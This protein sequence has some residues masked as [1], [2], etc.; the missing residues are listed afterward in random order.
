[1]PRVSMTPSGDLPIVSNEVEFVKV[2]FDVD[3]L[4]SANAEAVYVGGRPVA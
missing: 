1:M 4:K 3:V 2:E